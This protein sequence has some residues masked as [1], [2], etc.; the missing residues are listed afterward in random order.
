MLF[1]DAFVARMLVW[2]EALERIFFVYDLVSEIKCIPAAT[3]LRVAL[4]RISI[5]VLR[6]ALDRFC[7]SYPVAVKIIAVIERGPMASRLSLVLNIKY[8]NMI[9][10]RLFK[11]IIRE[12]TSEGNFVESL[13]FSRLISL[14]MLRYKAI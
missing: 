2:N 1:Q 9:F 14:K 6:E 13:R 3:F 8:I 12:Y 4:K 11:S 10:L 7:W 5:P